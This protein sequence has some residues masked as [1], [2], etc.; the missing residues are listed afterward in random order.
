MI[1]DETVQKLNAVIISFANGEVFKK[2]EAEAYALKTDSY[3]VESNVHFPTDYNL[4]WD[5][6]R[7]CIDM[8]DKVLKCYPELPGWRKLKDWRKRIRLIEQYRKYRISH[9]FRVSIN[10]FTPLYTS[11]HASSFVFNPPNYSF[12]IFNHLHP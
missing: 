6:G 1:T 4:L 8:V 2:K 3:V 10:L 9:H 12:Q 7:K 11:F 5:C